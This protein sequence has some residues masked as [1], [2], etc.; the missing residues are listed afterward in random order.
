M[1]TKL[2]E[3]QEIQSYDKRNNKVG[4]LQIDKTL[5]KC[6]RMKVFYEI[7]LMIRYIVLYYK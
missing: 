5:L 4:G 6:L 7:S 2:K 3:M 1:K